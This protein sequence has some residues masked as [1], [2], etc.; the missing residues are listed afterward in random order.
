MKLLKNKLK[1]EYYIFMVFIQLYNSFLLL[2]H[3]SFHHPINF[4]NYLITMNNYLHYNFK[5]NLI[6]E[7]LI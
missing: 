1:N 3:P 2:R 5:F 4:I 7:D 6:K